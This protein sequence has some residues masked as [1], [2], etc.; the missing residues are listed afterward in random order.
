MINSRRSF[1]RF[2]Q[3]M[4]VL[5]T[6][7]TLNACTGQPTPAVESPAAAASPTTRPTATHTPMIELPDGPFVWQGAT[8]PLLMAHFMP[9]YQAP[10]VSGSWGWHWTMDHFNPKQRQDGAWTE[11]ASHYTPLTGP[12]D[13]SDEAVLEYQTLLMKLSGIDGVIVDWYGI[14]DFWDYSAIHASTEKLFQAAEKAGLNFVICYED[15]TLKHMVD[16]QHLAEEDALAH[17]QEVMAFLQ[18]RWFGQDT[19]LKF[20]GKPVLFTFGPQYFKG[21]AWDDLFSTLDPQPLLITLDKHY[22]PSQTASFPWPPMWASQAG[23]LS[24]DKLQRYLTGFYTEAGTRNYVVGGAFPGFHDIYETAGVSSSYGYLDALDGKTFRFTLQE[25]LNQQPDMVQLITWND[26]GEGTNIEPTI[27]FEYRY[28]EMVQE[29]RQLTGEGD[30]PYQ[31][32]DLRLPFELYQLRV[33]YAQDETVR[34][35]LDEVYAALIASDVAAA[36]GLLEK[37]R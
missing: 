5:L 3:M 4:L 23:V 34:A 21:E 24:H 31:S 7:L 6:V 1:P 11:L 12:Y 9:W 28:L 35:Q 33:K 37:F 16:N 30:F 25:A 17:G 26:Y 10:T 2:K 27:E 20:S 19:Y 8:R 29:A 14:E 36:N 15:Q 18:D 22:V 32:S 13:S